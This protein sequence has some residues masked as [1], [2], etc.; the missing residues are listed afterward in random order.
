MAKIKDWRRSGKLINERRAIR[1]D[2]LSD[3]ISKLQ[4]MYQSINFGKVIIVNDR[5]YYVT[6]IEKSA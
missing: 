5:T 4:D 6:I 1:E 3:T 2:I